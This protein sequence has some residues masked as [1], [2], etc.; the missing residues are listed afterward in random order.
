MP[1]LTA[2]LASISGAPSGDVA[3]ACTYNLILW[4]MVK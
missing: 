1:L 2:E 4:N 3:K